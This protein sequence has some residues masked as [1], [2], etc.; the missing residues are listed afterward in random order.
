MGSTGWE[1]CRPKLWVWKPE[2]AE[3]KVKIPYGKG[4]EI[5]VKMEWKTSEVR[6]A[7]RKPQRGRRWSPFMT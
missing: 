2:E 3:E 6:A 1:A 7:E 4:K 5:E